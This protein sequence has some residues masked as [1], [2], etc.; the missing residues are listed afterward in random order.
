VAVI[1]VT[2][3]PLDHCVGCGQEL[4]AMPGPVV[5]R[6]CVHRVSRSYFRG[7]LVELIGGMEWHPTVVVVQVDGLPAEMR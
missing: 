1:V 4:A 5:C 7:S 6:T 3:V 2:T